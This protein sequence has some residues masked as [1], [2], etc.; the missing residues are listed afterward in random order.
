M[1]IFSF[2]F[3]RITIHNRHSGTCS[4]TAGV[5]G[6]ATQKCPLPLSERHRSRE[7]RAALVRT[8]I[9]ARERCGCEVTTPK[10]YRRG[11]KCELSSQSHQIGSHWIGGTGF[12]N[13]RAETKNEARATCKARRESEEMSPEGRREVGGVGPVPRFLCPR[14]KYPERRKSQ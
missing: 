10:S 3:V 6:E 8:S 13:R 12:S 9:F 7:T 4:S 5:K 2:S 11:A 1:F 14:M